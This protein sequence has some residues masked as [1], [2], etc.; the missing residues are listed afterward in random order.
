MK[1]LINRKYK[2]YEPKEQVAA[3][4]LLKRILSTSDGAY[5]NWVLEDIF[6]EQ[7]FFTTFSLW[8]SRENKEKLD[9][10]FNQY[11]VSLIESDVVKNYITENPILIGFYKNNFALLR[12]TIKVFK[13]LDDLMLLNGALD[14][15]SFF[16]LVIQQICKEAQLRGLE[17]MVFFLRRPFYWDYVNPS[18]IS[19]VISR[20]ELIKYATKRDI[21]DEC[22]KNGEIVGERLV[23][24]VQRD[25]IGRVLEDISK[26]EGVGEVIKRF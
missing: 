24:E 7:G 26:I 2:I 13:Y 10:A 9:I 6:Q 1:D 16:E 14:N 19:P 20:D 4:E 15:W 21:L 17:G 22:K 25:L 12:A 11:L 3:E 23:Q 8:E 18:G 5:I